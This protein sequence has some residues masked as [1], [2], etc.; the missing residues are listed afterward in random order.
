MFLSL[1]YAP[2]R[3]FE[4]KN[5]TW[6]FAAAVL[7]LL[8]ACAPEPLMSMSAVDEAADLAAPEMAMEEVAVVSLT[9]E[10][11]GETITLQVGQEVH[12]LLTGNPTTGYMWEAPQV[13]AALLR[14]AGEP[15]YAAASDALGSG[16]EFNFTFTAAAP[17]ETELAMIY[18][19]SFEQ[20]V[21]P[22]RTFSVNV[23][24]EE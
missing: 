4:M 3:R 5:W 19:R 1:G 18:H 24:I 12:V 15:D 20:D 16:G 22:K 10:N 23:V 11:D 17:G 8:T 9:E 7:L 6:I 21:P 13:D 14:P 2:K